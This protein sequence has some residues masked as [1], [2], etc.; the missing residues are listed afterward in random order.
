MD[1][2]ILQLEFRGPSIQHSLS[3]SVDY[4]WQ[5]MAARSEIAASRNVIGAL[6]VILAWDISESGHV[7]APKRATDGKSWKKQ[8]R[9]VEV[10]LIS[11]SVKCSSPTEPWQSFGGHEAASFVP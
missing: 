11:M 6:R 7:F 8:H 2:E 10:L 1:Q 3:Q 4:Y 5:I 9:S